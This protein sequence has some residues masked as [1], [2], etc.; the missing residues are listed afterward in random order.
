MGEIIKQIGSIVFDAAAV[1]V[2]D[3]CEEKREMIEET[4]RDYSL[5]KS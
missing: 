1:T 3:F 5:S 2:T 4:A